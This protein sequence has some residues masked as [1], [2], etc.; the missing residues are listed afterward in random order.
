MNYQEFLESK[1]KKIQD[2]GFTVSE[3]K[4]NPILFDFQN[5]IVRKA[6]LKGRFAIFADCGL[7]KTFMQTE[8][9]YHVTKHTQKPVLIL[10]PLAVA[11]QTIIEG[12]KLGIKIERLKAD[13]FGEG[14]Y[15]TNYDQLKNIDCSVFGGVV[16]DESSILKNFNG[17]L[18]NLIIDNFKSTP[19]KLA[20]TATPSP[21]DD[22]ELGNHSEFLGY[23]TRKEMMSVFFTTDKSIISG[24]KYKLKNHAVNDF[25]A[26][27]NNWAVMLEKPSDLKFKNTG[28]NLPRLNIIEENIKTKVTDFEHGELVKNNRVSATTYNKE[29]KNTAEIRMK[30]VVE[31]VKNKS[32]EQILIWVNRD[33]EADILRKLL[34]EAIEVRGSDK[35]EYKENKLLGFAKNEFR[36][37]ITKKKIAQYG[38]NYQNCHCQIH[39][40]LDFSFESMYQAIRRSYRFG[41][42]KQVDC[43]LITIDSMGNV[44]KA[45]ERKQEQFN[46][47]R[48]EMIKNLNSSKKELKK[49]K[50]QEFKDDN[51]HLI[52]GDSTKLIKELADNSIDFSF[53]SPP[54]AGL[55]VFSDSPQDMSNC[56]DYNEFITHFE[57][58]VKELYRVMR[59]GR[60]VAMHLMNFTTLKGAD[61]YY[62]IINMRD[63]IIRLF[64]KHGFYFH[65]ETSIKK[66]V[67]AAA[68]RTKNHQLMWGTTKK[69][70]LIVR[71]GM[72]DYIIVMRKD[73]QVDIEK[74]VCRNITFDQWCKYAEPIWE[75][76]EESDTERYRD[77]KDGKDE[78]HITPTQ[79]EPIKRVLNLYTNEGD[80]C[81]T[82][83]SGSGTELKQFIKHGCYGIGHELKE[84]YYNHSLKICKAESE[85][86]QQ[87]RLF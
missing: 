40:S 83:F 7:G 59:S 53:F 35:P 72:S 8:W 81:Y 36:I 3:D 16:L 49:I 34:P 10:A 5:Y 60:M 14:I 11:G 33:I 47:M 82:P 24:S 21:N 2:S 84:S 13:V 57:F 23:K 73:Q 55:Y 70:S 22:I 26:W 54:F 75:D 65:A 18:N 76:I 71:P 45:I 85:N 9:A 86:K 4:I 66:S 80:T 79:I 12:E 32:D 74:P 38:L 50:R 30:R 87:M 6:L 51:F 67:T 48:R 27:I 15:I 17:A 1:I 28:Y 19:Y 78:K 58:L 63:D 44:K 69:N 37:L 43:Y 68:V 42:K 56:Q 62:S 29:L 20:C 25:F 61:G 64:Q 41:Q 77:A 46:R 39:A 52:K 31:I